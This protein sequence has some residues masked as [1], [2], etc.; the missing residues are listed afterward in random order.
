MQSWIILLSKKTISRHI[1]FKFKLLKWRKKE[2]EDFKNSNQDGNTKELE[3]LGLK[4][5]NELKAFENK[6]TLMFNDLK[7]NRALETEKVILKYNNKNKDLANNQKSE[8]MDSKKPGKAKYNVSVFRPTSKA[9]FKN[10]VDSTSN[11][12]SEQNKSVQKV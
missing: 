7:K 9:G 3:T 8:L 11:K 2:E 12:H 5:E 4:Q 1:Q 10:M 6:M